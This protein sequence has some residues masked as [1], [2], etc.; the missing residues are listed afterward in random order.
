MARIV[1]DLHCHTVAST[2]AYGTLKEMVDAAAAQ[3]LSALAV[4][5]HAPALPD[6]PHPWHFDNQRILPRRIGGVLL[7]R[8]VEANIVDLAG[9]LDLEDR[10][11]GMLDWVIASFHDVVCLPGTP[12]QNTEA[13]LAVLRNPHV[14]ALGHTGSHQFPYDVDAV[15][16]ACRDA[17]RA[18]EINSGSFKV[19]P[20]AIPNCRRIA[21]ACRRLSCPVVV[22]SDAHCSWDVGVFAPALAMLDEVGF[23]D[24]LILNAD[25]DRLVR[26]IE[27]RKAKRLAP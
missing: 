17:G 1:A 20:R 22:T 5:D 21:E 19:R 4:T 8:G 2:H 6:A 25:L 18:I 24:E 16:T 10:I 12:E 26:F 7:L 14:D 13:Y 11:L 9:T 15:V 3:G 27:G 23:P